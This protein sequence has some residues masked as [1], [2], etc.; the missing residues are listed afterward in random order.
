LP[1]L[2]S[3]TGGEIPD[4][5]IEAL[6]YVMPSVG[7]L[8]LVAD[9]GVLLLKLTT[10]DGVVMTQAT[11]PTGVLKTLIIET[12]LMMQ[13]S[14]FVIATAAN[15]LAITRLTSYEV[16]GLS[17]AAAGRVSGTPALRPPGRQD[18]GRN[19]VFANGFL[20]ETA[21]GYD[22]RRQCP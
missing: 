19:L 8:K 3:L 15:V 5:L 11:M 17:K 13:P 22:S 12:A 6:R 14:V 9:G 16:G 20:K 7:N 18:L 10:E 4:L 1:F 21:A 2:Y